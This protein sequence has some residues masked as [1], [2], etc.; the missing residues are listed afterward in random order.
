MS[1]GLQTPCNDS[2]VQWRYQQS[3]IIAKN[4]F[5]IPEPDWS[6]NFTK[7]FAKETRKYQKSIC[8]KFL[9]IVISDKLVESVVVGFKAE[10][11]TRVAGDLQLLKYSFP[12]Y[13]TSWK[14]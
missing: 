6:S 5:E 11:C 13:H 8:N 3:R 4:K 1:P 9:R 7:K 12:D 2:H 14:Q 10:V